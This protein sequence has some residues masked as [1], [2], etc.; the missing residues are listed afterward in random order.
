[1]SIRVHPW[2][3]LLVFAGV[4]GVAEWFARRALP[5]VPA[6][7]QVS[8]NPY[9]FRGWP[10]YTAL[11]PAQPG[12]A[13]L[14]LLSNSQAYAGEI[15]AS[16]IYADKLERA[17]TAQR[18]GGFE[19]VEVLNWSF[20]GVTSIELTLLATRLREA[21]PELVIAAVGVADFSAFNLTRPMSQCR[22]DLPRLATR[23]AIWRALPDA[24]TERHVD[25]EDWLTYG[26][27]DRVALL[28]FRD[29]G[30]AWLDQQ[31]GGLQMG[32]YSPAINYHPWRLDHLP[33]RGAVGSPPWRRRGKLEVRYSPEARELVVEFLD[34]FRAIP[35][36]RHL[37]IATPHHLEPGDPLLAHDRAFLADLAAL[38]AERDLAFWDDHALF[39]AEAFLDGL[40]FT[41]DYHQ[42]Y[43][44]R[45]FERLPP[46]LAP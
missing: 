24:F 34:A 8:R 37:V 10:E 4:L 21:S 43:C 14:V 17:L 40:H 26:A 42:Y 29:F 32:L 13:R 7:E 6:S 20:D 39:P 11:A 12:V 9:R 2:F 5:A 15:P 46:L 25:I 28:R 19:K 41:P 1:M 18:V 35:A 33:K 30:W 44:E 36:K 16:R 27:W 45:L 38:T 22:T 23:P 31:W 3:A